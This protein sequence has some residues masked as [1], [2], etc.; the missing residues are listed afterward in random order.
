MC[1]DAAGERLALPKR[2][3]ARLFG[4]HGRV[5]ADEEFA[6]G[7]RAHFAFGSPQSDPDHPAL[8][9]MDKRIRHLA[10]FLAAASIEHSHPVQFL[11]HIQVSRLMSCNFSLLCFRRGFLSFVL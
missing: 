7:E 2:L 8:G 9:R 6:G 5:Y 10:Q 4:R 11:R 3:E 1:G